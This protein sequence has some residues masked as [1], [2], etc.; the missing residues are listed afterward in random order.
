ME[1][2]LFL[3]SVK[4][5]NSYSVI[6]STVRLSVSETPHSFVKILDCGVSQTDVPYDG[7]SCKIKKK[8][9]LIT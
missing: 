4:C 7:R 2:S 5:Q 9:I 3:P 1:G 6:Q 8:K